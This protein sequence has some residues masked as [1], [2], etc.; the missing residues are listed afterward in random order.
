MMS[1]ALT[2]TRRLLLLN[3]GCIALITLA[4]Q[5]TP[6][7]ENPIIATPVAGERTLPTEAAPLNIVFMV[8]DGMGLGQLSAGM[9]VNDDEIAFE[10]MKTVGLH[11]PRS[12]DNLVTDSAA[13]A[14][15]FSCGVKTYNGAIG[16]NPDGS[17][18][19]TILEYAHD[20]GMPTGL[21]V[22]STIVHATPAAFFAH[23]GLRSSYENIAAQL[24]DASVDF[25]IGGGQKFFQQRTGD[26]RDLV[27][28]MRG[29][30][31]VVESYFD[32]TIDQ[33]S[34]SA[35]TTYGYFTA[36]NDPL[37]A[38]QGRTYLAPASTLALDYLAARDTAGRGFF[39]MIEGSQIDWGGHANN[40]E[41][42]VTEVTDFSRTVDA[43]LDWAAARG[44]TLVVVTAD[45]ETGGFA[46]NYGSRPDSMIYAFTT[47]YHTA[48][49]IPVFAEGPGA[50]AFGGMYENTEI[51][52]K[53][54]SAIGNARERRAR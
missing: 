2:G 45:H 53:L 31:R 9:F 22:T 1:Y 27:A 44:N 17:A 11:K 42:I 21:V 10:R 6:V 13:G 46:V 16:V 52:T 25:F 35:K 41:Y 15:A 38:S 32:K 54:R 39:L 5:R 7:R 24:N 49:I 20:L 37:P 36:D 4:C 34:A 8:A 14:T 33:V 12:S 23:E 50:S 19:P 40:G 48:T 47:D 3:C 43:V 18:C 51:Y 30:G 29:R 28:E 26:T